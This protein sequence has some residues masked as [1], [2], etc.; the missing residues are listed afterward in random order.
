MQMYFAY[1]S[2]SKIQP[3]IKNLTDYLTENK[4]NIDTKN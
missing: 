3:V 2:N 4:I 1:L